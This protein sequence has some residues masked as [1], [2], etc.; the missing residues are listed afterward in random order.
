M[1]RDARYFKALLEAIA[2]RNFDI[3]R[4]LD[5]CDKGC[6]TARGTCTQ[7]CVKP[8]STLDDSDKRDLRRLSWLF[9]DESFPRIFNG[10]CRSYQQARPKERILAA[11]E[12]AIK[13]GA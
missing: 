4:L 5:G 13:R 11:I 3:D 6:T 9:T 12:D 10:Q 2:D 8:I 7:E 1:A